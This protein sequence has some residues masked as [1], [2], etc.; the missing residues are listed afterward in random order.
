MWRP[1]STTGITCSETY[2]GPVNKTDTSQSDNMDT[3]NYP[4][5]GLA[6]T[7]TSARSSPRLSASDK[8]GEELADRNSCSQ[9]EQEDSGEDSESEG[10]VLLT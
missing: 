5:P 6:T 10:G 3:L 8:G 7:H 1:D 4:K 9:E 2:N